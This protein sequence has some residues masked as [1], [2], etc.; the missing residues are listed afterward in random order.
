MSEKPPAAAPRSKADRRRQPLRALWIGSLRPRRM[1][2]R[3]ASDRSVAGVDWHH[4]QWLAVAIVI[5]LL[6][7]TDAFLTLAVIDLGA[8][9]ANPFM[10]PLVIGSG[11]SFALWK[12]GMTALG[13]VMLTQLARLRAFGRVPVSLLLYTALL[14]YVALVSYELWLLDHLTYGYL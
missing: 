4:P 6:S 11:R 3:R 14:A 8:E 9:E 13:V 2:P 1:G 5:L 10:A 12:F 7:V